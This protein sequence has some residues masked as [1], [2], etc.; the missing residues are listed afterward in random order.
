MAAILSR[1]QCLKYAHPILLK[2]YGNVIKNN[3]VRIVTEA[4]QNHA[5][6]L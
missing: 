2:K 4:S 6:P 5:W 3:D 1:P